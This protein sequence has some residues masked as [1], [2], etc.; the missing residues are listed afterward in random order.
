MHPIPLYAASITQ[1]I[2][3]GDLAAMRS[4]QASAEQHL[5]QYGDVKGLLNLLKVEIARTEAKSA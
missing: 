4:V 3:T 5:S 1:A 2:A